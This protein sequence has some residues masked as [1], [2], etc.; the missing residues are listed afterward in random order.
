VGAVPVDVDIVKIVLVAAAEVLADDVD[1][2]KSR[3]V[4]ID[5]GIENRD[6][7]SAAGSR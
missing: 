2:R 3:V 4:L 7:N 1:A 5:S 6:P